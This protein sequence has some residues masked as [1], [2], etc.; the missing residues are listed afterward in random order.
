MH[1]HNSNRQNNKH[2]LCISTHTKKST[3]PNHKDHPFFIL[4]IN[5]STKNLQ[6]SIWKPIPIPIP[7]SA[8]REIRGLWWVI[9]LTEKSSS[10]SMI[11]RAQRRDFDEKGPLWFL[12][13]GA[14]ATSRVPIW[15][16]V[17]MEKKEQS[18][19]FFNNVANIAPRFIR[20]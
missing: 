8:E 2:M 19:S 11:Y 5:K 1:H 14:I 20:K 16:I 7:G 6:E 18:E 12:I 10:C 3:V 17:F 9:K 13:G 15:N 4:K